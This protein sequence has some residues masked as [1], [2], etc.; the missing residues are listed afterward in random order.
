VT[1]L[2]EPFKLSMN[3]KKYLE[4]KRPICKY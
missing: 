3:L 4:L 1:W 2:E